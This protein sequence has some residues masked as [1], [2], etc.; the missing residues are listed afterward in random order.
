MCAIT[1]S[2]HLHSTAGFSMATQTCGYSPMHQTV[3]RYR[4]RRHWKYQSLLKHRSRAANFFSDCSAHGWKLA[5]AI[6]P[7]SRT[8][9]ADIIV[10][11]EKL[12][13]DGAANRLPGHC[14][15]FHC[16]D[17]TSGCIAVACL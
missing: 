12:M 10:C 9:K 1:V 5:Y 3:V 13:Y 16:V 11:R 4:R 7:V 6:F 17:S 2:V 15:A 8:T 14:I